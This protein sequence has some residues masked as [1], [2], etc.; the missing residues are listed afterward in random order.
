[1]GRGACK[2]PRRPVPLRCGSAAFGMGESG[3][4]RYMHVGECVDFSTFALGA[5]GRKSLGQVWLLNKPN[6]GPA[7]GT[8]HSRIRLTFNHTKLHCPLAA[9][10][11]VKSLYRNLFHFCRV[12]M[13]NHPRAGA[14]DY[15][16]RRTISWSFSLSRLRSAT[17]SATAFFFDLLRMT[18]LLR[19]PASYMR[20][21]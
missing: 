19:Q 18:H 16:F 5:D 13:S 15:A 10:S 11:R 6:I 8:S 9:K 12:D 2:V 14:A 3:P 7:V 20:F 21:S 4:F 1:M 17:T